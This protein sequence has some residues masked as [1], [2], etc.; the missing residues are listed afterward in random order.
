MTRS[1]RVEIPL[2][3]R[4]AIAKSKFVSAANL[5]NCFVEPVSKSGGA[6]IYGDPGLSSFCEMASTSGRGVYAF[7]DVLLAVAGTSIYSVTSAGVKTSRGTIAGSTAVSMSDNGTQAMIV[8]TVFSYIL[9]SSTLTLAQITDPDFFTASSVDFID[10]YMVTSVDD[11]GRF[12]ISDL[13]DA[14]AYDALDIATAEAKPDKLRRVL[15]QNNEVLL[16]GYKTVE[17]RYNSGAADFPFSKAPTFVEYGLIG[18][19]AACIVDNTVAW[20]DHLLNV[21]L[22]R[23]GT[24]TIISGPEIAQQIKAWTDP[25]LTRFF[26]YTLRGHEFLVAWNPSGCLVWDAMTQEWHEKKSQGL[27][28]W[29]ICAAVRIWDQDIGQDYQTG[30]LFVIDEDIYDEDGDALI[31][32]F[33]TQTLGPNGKPF[34]LDAVEIEI[35]PGVGLLSGQGSAPV[36]WMQLSRDSGFT[37]GAR[38]ERS[39]GV[40]GD[41]AL[42]IRWGGPYG[43]FRPHGGVIKVGYSDPTSWTLT[44][45]WVEYREDRP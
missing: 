21:R 28:T 9:P 42:R 17:S 32:E 29:R 10:Q 7:G 39:I 19:D 41:R 3:I 14:S 11:T 31:R 23:G 24:A 6:A 40:R 34:T 37:Y 15:V 12:Q 16:M 43:Q 26:S 35:E 5:Y 38:I 13:A 36:C 4:D 25:S 45:I 20:L 30:D 8:G 27:D 1:T 18:R 2:P 22:L 44:R 33:V